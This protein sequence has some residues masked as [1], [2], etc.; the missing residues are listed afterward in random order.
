MGLAKMMMIDFKDAV[1]LATN[2]DLW[3]NFGSISI[4][5][6]PSAL[7]LW[8]LNMVNINTFVEFHGT[9]ASK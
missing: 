4:L 5:R 6:S 9:F 2:K 8:T 3:R 7:L 1:N